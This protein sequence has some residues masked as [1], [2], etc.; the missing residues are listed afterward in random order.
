MFENVEFIDRYG[1]AGPPSWLRG[2]HGDCEATGWIPAEPDW[3]HCPLCAG[4]G[5][6]S[7]L[8]TFGR[9][10]RWLWRGVHWCWTMGPRSEV[11][12]GHPFPYAR[13]AWLTFKIA[14]LCDLGLRMR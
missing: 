5:R 11:W 13:R 3:F 8:A 9:I 6:C 14:F 1:S 7:W 12:A 10:P 2:C 4:T